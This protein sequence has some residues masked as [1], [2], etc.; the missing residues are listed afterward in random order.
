MRLRQQLKK[1]D[2]RNWSVNVS[3]KRRDRSVKRK[4]PLK[5]LD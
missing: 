4:K 5:R 1:K 3:K 2:K